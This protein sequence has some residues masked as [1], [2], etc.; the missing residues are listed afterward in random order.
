M[1]EL[2]L[3]LERDQLVRRRVEVAVDRRDDDE[4]D[5]RSALVE[6][7]GRHR[8]PELLDALVGRCLVGPFGALGPLDKE[9]VDGSHDGPAAFV[10]DRGL[11]RDLERAP[12]PGLDE[13]HALPWLDSPQNR[14]LPRWCT[15]AL[16]LMQAHRFHAEASTA[17]HL[18]DRLRRQ[19]PMKVTA[20]PSYETAFAVPCHTMSGRPA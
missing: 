1:Q 6:A 12:D 8:A 19:S 2:E 9:R 4:V 3:T 16:R 18:L 11:R 14:S 15:A 17:D 7:P 13:A 20:R 10:D 5:V